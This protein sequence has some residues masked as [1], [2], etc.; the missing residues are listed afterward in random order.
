MTWNAR[1]F[2]FFNISVIIHSQVV[3]GIVQVIFKSSLIF[4]KRKQSVFASDH[5]DFL[6]G[7]HRKQGYQ[8]QQY[9]CVLAASS[10][11]LYYLYK[12]DTIVT[13]FLT[14]VCKPS[15]SKGSSMISCTC[16]V[17]HIIENFE[18]L[19]LDVSQIQKSFQYHM[20]GYTSQD[21]PQLKV[22]V[23]PLCNRT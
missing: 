7:A 16:W 11:A 17:V 19:Y 21:S 10:L 14:R 5:L 23:T 18:L 3:T 20:A 2:F 12:K 8:H 13:I 6:T 9:H 1:S 15:L 4:W 22:C